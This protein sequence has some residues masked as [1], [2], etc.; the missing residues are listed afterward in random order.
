MF[1][2]ALLAIAVLAALVIIGMSPRERARRVAKAKVQE[3]GHWY[4]ANKDNAA[5]YAAAFLASNPLDPA[6]QAR[7]ANMAKTAHIRDAARTEWEAAK[8]DFAKF[9]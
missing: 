1:A 4:R 9:A 6:H 2:L 5:K 7:Y 3:T 8:A